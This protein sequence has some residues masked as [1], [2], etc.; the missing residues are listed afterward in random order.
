MNESIP[1][2]SGCIIEFN[3]NTGFGSIEENPTKRILLFHLNNVKKNAK[4]YLNGDGEFIGELFDFNV[5]TRTKRDDCDETDQYEAINIRHRIVI[6]NF[7]GCQ[8]IKAFTNLKALEDH[9]NSRHRLKK[10]VHETPKITVNISAKK[11]NEISSKMSTRT[12][13]T[14]TD[15]P[16]L[17]S[18]GRFIGKQGINLKRFEQQNH[19]KLKLLDTRNISKPLQIRVMFDQ[20]AKVN[21]QQ[22]TKILKFQWDC[23]TL[24]QELQ[25]QLYQER[26]RSKTEKSQ[27]CFLHFVSDSRRKMDS[28]FCDAK[29]LQ[30]EKLKEK[31]KYNQLESSIRVQQ[32][33]ASVNL[34]GH[35]SIASCD[36]QYRLK[37]IFN[38]FQPKKTI[39]MKM[40][41]KQWLIRDQLEDLGVL[42]I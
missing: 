4:R 41:E 2:S 21:I 11:K 29:R 8:R 15:H 36:K 35:R 9:I 30:H 1:L 7:E 14:L 26:L 10:K 27:T 17:A 13:I 6:C 42:S 22:L 20:N 12:L 18:I 5:I 39:G 24:H 33:H 16:T 37:S 28:R 34:E 19:V 25:E 31:R 32:R 3:K 38:Y 23:S 40:K